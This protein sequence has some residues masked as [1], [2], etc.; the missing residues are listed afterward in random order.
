M[1]VCVREET[2]KWTRFTDLCKSQFWGWGYENEDVAVSLRRTSP[3]I[4]ARSS[5][6]SGQRCN[7]PPP[8]PLEY[9]CKMPSLSN[10]AYAEHRMPQNA[11]PDPPWKWVELHQV[12]SSSFLYCLHVSNE[13][14]SLLLGGFLCA[15]ALVWTRAV[16]RH[17]C[18]TPTLKRQEW[19]HSP[20]SYKGL[21]LLQTTRVCIFF[22]PI[23]YHYDPCLLTHLLPPS[24]ALRKG[25]PWEATSKVC[26]NN[27]YHSLST[28]YV[29]D[30][31]LSI[32]FY[33]IFTTL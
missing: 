17:L 16:P 10:S 33:L 30:I 32:L 13:I 4:T 22:S 1:D 6:K 2:K 7:Q 26:S 28:Y 8:S 15:P 29:W 23:C 27:R 18:K 21:D 12:A 25:S 3:S 24:K 19:S 14:Q 11:E 20:E 31:V 9:N 5:D